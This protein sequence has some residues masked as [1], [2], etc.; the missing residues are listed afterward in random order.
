MIV[1][2]HP[3]QMTGGFGTLVLFSSLISSSQSFFSLAVRIIS[4]MPAW[5]GARKKGQPI[6]KAPNPWPVILQLLT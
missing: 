3:K 6:K 2:K 5:R 1:Q 4:H